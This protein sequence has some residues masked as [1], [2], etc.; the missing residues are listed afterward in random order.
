MKKILIIDHSRLSWTEIKDYLDGVYD[1]FAVESGTEAI[2]LAKRQP[3][4][5]ILLDM[6][7]PE[8][9]G[10]EICSLLNE[11]DATKYIPLILLSAPSQK[12]DIINGLYAG[13]CDY[14]TKPVS[15]KQLLARIDTHLRIKEYYADLEKQDLLMLLELLE[16]ISVTRN[17]NR[18][19]RMIV[20][21]MVAAIDVSRCSIIALN[22]DGELIVKASSD[23][24]VNREI[25][26]DLEKYPEIEKALITEKP[27]VLQDIHK[28]PL[29][30]PVRDK[31]EGLSDQAIFVVPIINK[32]NVIGTFFLRTASP[33]K[34]W[35]SARIFKLCLLV[36]KM[37]GNALENA[38][39]FEAMHS[40]RQLL[41]EVAVRDS[42]TGLY[43]HQ[44]FHTRLEEEFS[45]AQRYSL[46]LSCVFADID[47]F[48]DINDNYGHIIGDVVL[49]QIGKLIDSIVRN[50]DIAARYG[51]DEFA[52][53]LPNTETQGAIEFVHRLEKE[54]GELSI[55]QLKDKKIS[56]SVGVA[57]YQE[58]N[59]SSPQDLVQ[60]ADEAM[61]VTKQAK[62]EKHRGAGW[63]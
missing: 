29:M 6:E 52:V 51:G 49:K 36:A 43:N 32:Q 17:P 33:I 16:T 35:V 28:D 55:Q 26:I 13:A 57:T 42:L 63:T 47:D 40:H 4:D 15:S 46:A 2:D 22:G 11:T 14:L 3:L 45:R 31:I 12:V 10:S 53:L 48:K 62:K 25:K 30:A 44:Y 60:R 50:S 38:V 37:S 58:R 5:L 23:L 59:L 1:V 19:L 34:Q 61:Y 20:E 21:K 39:I 41:E 9:N 54:I 18:I 24:P 56:I 7:M 8:G 27:V